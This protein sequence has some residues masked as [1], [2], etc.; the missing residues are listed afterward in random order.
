MNKVFILVILLLTISCSNESKNEFAKTKK[1]I[2]ENKK[3]SIKQQK[4]DIPIIDSNLIV[5]DTATNLIWTKHDFSSLKGRFLNEWGEVFEW[6]KEMNSKQYAGIKDWRVPTIKE[7]RTINKNK[8]DR[9]S[10]KTTF[11]Q[12]DTNCVWGKGP[13]SFWSVTTPNENTA[14][15]ISF[16]DGFATSGDREKKFSNPYSSWKGVELG[17]SVRLVKS[18]KK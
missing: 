12:L 15:Y 13:Y 18:I 16:I 8:K 14:S 10:Y 1:S 6:E 2:H 7:Y 17:M 9:D 3:D 4:E 5:I 11:I